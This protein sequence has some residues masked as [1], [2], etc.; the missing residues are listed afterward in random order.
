[1]PGSNKKDESKEV[2]QK[3][4]QEEVEVKTKKPT[5]SEDDLEDNPED[6]E[7][8]RER[9]RRERQLRQMKQAQDAAYWDEFTRQR[10]EKDEIITQTKIAEFEQRVEEQRE[11]IHQVFGG[12]SEN[13]GLN[14]NRNGYDSSETGDP[15]L[16]WY[17][18]SEKRRKPDKT[19][20]TEM[21]PAPEAA[22]ET[23]TKEETTPEEETPE[24]VIPPMKEAKIEVKEKN[25]IHACKEM[26][27]IPAKKAQHNSE[28]YQKIISALDDV[29]DVLKKGYATATEA[30][31]A[32]VKSI[33]KVLNNI[34]RYRVH[35]AADGVDKNDVENEKIIAIECVDQYLRMRY[36][37]FVKK[38]Y[39][40]EI[41]AGK[42]LFNVNVDSG[43]E[44]DEYILDKGLNKI[45]NMKK[46]ID[47]LR[48]HKGGAKV[49]EEPEV[50]EEV[51]VEIIDEH[52]EEQFSE[53]E[54]Q[55]VHNFV[56]EL[57]DLGEEGGQLE[58]SEE[59]DAEEGKER[60]PEEVQGM[61][62]NLLDQDE[63]E[64]END[65]LE[66]PE[67]P[68]AVTTFVDGLFDNAK[69]EL[70][71]ENA[72]LPDDED[73]EAEPEEEIAKGEEEPEE[74][75][76]KGEA[77]PEEEIVKGEE[78]PEEEIVK[79]EEVKP[80]NLQVENPD[81]KQGDEPEEIQ[82]DEIDNLNI[83]ALRGEEKQG[84]EK[85]EE[86]MPGEPLYGDYN[87][88]EDE[89]EEGLAPSDLFRRTLARKLT[90]QIKERQEREKL[91]KE[92]QE[93]REQLK[94]NKKGAENKH[95]LKRPGKGNL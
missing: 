13:N 12:G 4:Y 24:E 28:E 86:A 71:A 65:A 26:L 55:T 73:N 33:K 44:G 83:G 38:D 11:M 72:L 10:V 7:A 6:S 15:E 37:E 91:E 1:M 40:D 70:D 23:E 93:Q 39:E 31:N 79:G 64:N 5:A 67:I 78:E 74:E 94:K 34:N 53:E 88:L 85:Q 48:A 36:K 32:Y 3:D 19:V 92:R 9:K 41:G 42:G 51:P 47:H 45:D 35:K 22:G 66:N 54:R 58:D 8:E 95:E 27:S 84:E 17:R 80:E 87:G 56:D 30:K 60:V 57:F 14:A 63:P 50:G 16:K 21:K 25:F 2:N 18:N 82:E 75:I 81:G 59:A 49:E 43:K 29:N 52:P 76:V 62:Q 69:E 20:Q 61:V 46:E 89:D 68:R 77:E 90:I